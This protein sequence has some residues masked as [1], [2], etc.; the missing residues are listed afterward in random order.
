[1]TAAAGPAPPSARPLLIA[2]GSFAGFVAL[3]GVAFAAIPVAAIALVGLA[4]GAVALAIAFAQPRWVLVAAV[5]VLTTYVIDNGREAFALPLR[6]EMP[7]LLVLFFAI[8]RALSRSDRLEL[9]I[10]HILLFVAL[11]AAMAISMSGALDGDVASAR[12]IDYFKN[13][14]LVVLMLTLFDRPVWLRRALW[15]FTLAAAIYAAAAVAQQLLGLHANDLSGFLRIKPDRGLLRSGGPY[16]PNVFG[17][18]LLVGSLISLYLGIASRGLGRVFWFGAS[19][20]SAAGL[21]YTYSRAAL[22]VL[23][24]CLLVVSRLRRVPAWVPVVVAAAV[25]VVGAAAVPASAKEYFGALKEPLTV[26][27]A[28]AGDESLTVRFGQQLASAKMFSDHPFFGV[29]PDNYPVRYGEYSPEIGLD[30]SEEAASHN[31]YLQYFA[32]TGLFGATAL[33]LLLGLAVAGAYRARRVM[34]GRDALVA[35]GLLVGLVALLLNSLFLH[36]TGQSRHLWIVIGLGLVAGRLAVAERGEAV[37]EGR[38][39][40]GRVGRPATAPQPVS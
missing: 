6:N 22:L 3:V 29:G 23:V 19:A 32:E 2:Y 20:V 10:G 13:A 37:P 12:L 15:A 16:D 36:E 26:G 24:V 8:G 34:H 39:A 33:L 31:L 5:F 27:F 30:E 28:R 11:G 25:V 17:Q 1:M 38:A 21:F 18:L 35:E 40:G 4:M 7:L 14:F 9:P